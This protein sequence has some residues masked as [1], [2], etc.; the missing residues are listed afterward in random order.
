MPLEIDLYQLTKKPPSN[1]GPDTDAHLSGG[2]PSRCPSDLRRLVEL[3]KRFARLLKESGASMGDS[4]AGAMPFEQRYAKLVF[5]RP[6][7]AAD[8]GRPDAQRKRGSS[9][10]QLL[11]DDKGPRN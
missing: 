11:G 2:A 6:H 3:F 10:A 4:H 5:E 9:E 7:A 1:R 8:S